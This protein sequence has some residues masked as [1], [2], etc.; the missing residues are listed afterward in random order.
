MCSLFDSLRLIHTKIQTLDVSGAGFQ[1]DSAFTFFTTKIKL[2]RILSAA[3]NFVVGLSHAVARADAVTYRT[4]SLC[5]GST[6]CDEDTLGFT[7]LRVL[8]T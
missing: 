1:G 3:L 5:L 6:R 4:E 2:H 7:V 8:I